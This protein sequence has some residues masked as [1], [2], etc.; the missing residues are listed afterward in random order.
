[1][2]TTRKIFIR[3]KTWGTFTDNCNSLLTVSLNGLTKMTFYSQLTKHII[4][5]FVAYVVFTQIHNFY[6]IS[7]S[8]T[9]RFQSIIFDKRITFLPRILNLQTKCDKSLNILKFLLNTSWGADRVHM[10]KIYRAVT[11]SKIEY[12]CQ[13]CSSTRVFYLKEKKN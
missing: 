8:Y 11:R 3:E 12:R 13:V 5:T 7:V 10:L 6:Q 4:C 2:L 9:A 1:M